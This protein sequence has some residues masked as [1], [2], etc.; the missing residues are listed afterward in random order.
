VNLRRAALPVLGPAL[1]LAVLTLSCRDRPPFSYDFEEPGILDDLSWRCRTLYRI[2][3]DHATSGA[4]SLEVT[5]FPA[6]AED[7]ENYPGVSLPVPNP[8][9]TGRKTLVFDVYNPQD[10]TIR[11]TLRIDDRRGPMY[12][13]RLNQSFAVSP[14]ANRISIPLG[15]M[16]TSGSRRPLN[17][18]NIL[19]VS[20]F[21]ANPRE[22]YTLHLDR[23][24][25]E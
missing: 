25:L 24:R 16:A 5:F 7:R 1:S 17:L 6:P 18:A 12:P 19:R 11:L 10:V 14:G 15:G 3:P 8:D 2:S 13:E 23:V 20:L 4:R 9:W 21:M 22:R